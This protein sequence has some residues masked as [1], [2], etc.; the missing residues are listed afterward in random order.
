MKTLAVVTF[1][2]ATTI[3]G[4]T[5]TPPA[6]QKTGKAE[7]LR[8][9]SRK[10]RK[11]RIAKLE[12][13]H[14]DFIG[15]VAPI[16]FDA[17]LDTFL[18]L[19]SNAQR[20]AFVEEFWRRRDLALGGGT[21]RFKQVYSNRLDV[22]KQQ[23]RRIDTDRA[24]MFLLHGPPAAIVRAEC[25]RVLQ[26]IEIWKYEMLPGLGAEL[27]LVFYKPRGSGEY[28][29]WNP[30][31]GSMAV[32]DL[33]VGDNAVGAEEPGPR[34]SQQA[35]QSQSP[36]AS[37]NRIQMECKDGEELMRAITQMV[38]LRVDL[39]RLFEPP[40]MQQEED[41]QKILRS[42][43]IANPNAPKLNTEF[44]VRYPGKQGSRTDVQM[45]LLIPR[46]ELQAAEVNGA[47][48]YTINVTGEILKDDQLW[49]KY[50]YRFDFP[51]DT[52]GEQLPIVIDRFLRP[53]DYLSRIKI[54]DANGGAEAVVE[55][56][57]TVPEVFDAETPRIADAAPET[58]VA[59]T[60][61][62]IAP[63]AVAEP[64]KPALRIIPPSDGIVSGI[65]TVETILSGEG[66]KSVEFW[67]DGRKLAVRRAAP[68]AI[69]LDFGIVPHMRRIR[70][71]GLDASGQP[72]AGDDIFVNA[73]TDPFQVRIVS[74]RVA[75]HLVGQA[76]IEMDV[77]VPEGEE[78][79]S[80][81]LYFN[82][83]RLATLYDPPFVQ[84]IEVPKTDGGVG[85]IRA[86]ARLK[87][88]STPPIEDVVMINTPSYM[89]E[90]NVHLVELPTTVT[91]NGKPADNLTEKSFKVLDE[92]TPVVI[93]KFEHVRN[94][95]LSI[96]LAFDTS[97]SMA[98]RLDEA[99]KAGA[100]FFENVMRKGDKGF[101]ISFDKEPRL[102]Q[103]WTTKV[104]DIHAGLAKLRAEEATSLYD[105]V[106]HG[107]YHFHGLRGQKALILISDGKD[108]AS[109]FTFDQAMEY[110]RR[111]AVPIYAIGIGIRGTEQDV[112]YKLGKLTGETGGS[113]YYIEQARDLRR[114]Y[115]EIQTELRS[116]Y[117]LGFYPAP[118]VK[119]GSK[120]REVTVQAAEGKVKTV[121]GYFP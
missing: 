88:A 60:A 113:V 12:I 58:R 28:R 71:V 81:E 104:A 8:K 96:G 40:Q 93:S 112:R 82:E 105:A 74:P 14:Q 76:R 99:Q 17:E 37:L 49:E 67:L 20:D 121:K 117:I 45:A 48:V 16:I 91:V 66:I 116:Q 111:S 50:R 27:R 51:G 77:R 47:E 85:Y 52:Q 21:G 54:T 19:E 36:Y 55:K 24:K 110:A 107:L 80:L 90:L 29:L 119:S 39:L 4:Q 38:Q 115:D 42:M 108:T 68:Y 118:D 98:P 94:L 87:D 73:G 2:L 10:E 1:A 5:A 26:P 33:L 3:L 25:Q 92:G 11:E 78:L 22:A 100:E 64:P 101:L 75:P 63:A 34:R 120:W 102:V 6:P 18:A 32:N 15:D 106:V 44:S 83:T 114:V 35:A 86:V 109:K 89:E 13:R 95:P 65:Q 30:L 9:L 59:P 79:E 57:L 43:V 53:N 61:A 7:T 103:G 69:D 97:G 70:A 84:T 23:F 41:A 46:A 62:A 31:G 72:V 56:P